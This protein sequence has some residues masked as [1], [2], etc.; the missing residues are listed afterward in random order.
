[1]FVCHTEISKMYKSEM[2]PESVIVR[3]WRFKTRPQD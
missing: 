1:V 3:P 2:W